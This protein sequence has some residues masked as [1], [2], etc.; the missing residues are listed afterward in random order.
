MNQRVCAHGMPT[1]ASCVECMED[2]PVAVTESASPLIVEY[3][4]TA[5]YDDHC[6][7]CNLPIH[8]G[9]R[10]AKLVYGGVVHEGCE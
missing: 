9:Q 5:R 7:G 8:V 6:R 3:W 10:A 1:P 2:G 4:F